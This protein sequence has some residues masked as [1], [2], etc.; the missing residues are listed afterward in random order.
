MWNVSVWLDD[1]E[2]TP[3]LRQSLLASATR[4]RTP[5]QSAQLSATSPTKRQRLADIDGNARQMTERTPSPVKERDTRRIADVGVFDEDDGRTPRQTR[6][7]SQK[8]AEYLTNKNPAS[9]VL[10]ARFKHFL[11]PDRAD[12]SSFPTRSS[13]SQASGSTSRSKSPVKDAVDLQVADIPIYQRTREE[14]GIP[15][16]AETLCKK[17][18]DIADGDG[19]VPK[20][21]AERMKQHGDTKLRPRHLAASELPFSE[22]DLDDFKQ[23]VEI[24]ED[25]R[26]LEK[27]NVHEAAWNSEVHSSVFRLALRPHKK[28]IWY[29]NIT[30]ARPVPAF[31]PTQASR[32]SE[33]RLVDYSVNIMPTLNEQRAIER[34]ISK[35]DEKQSTITQTRTTAVRTRPCVISIETKTDSGH[36]KAKNQLAVWGAAHFARMSSLFGPSREEEGANLSI[37]QVIHVQLHDWK[38]YLMV[39]RQA[40]MFIDE[41]DL[42][43]CI[44][45]TKSLLELWKLRASVRCLAQWAEE[46]YW[47]VLWRKLK[48]LEEN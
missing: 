20:L 42:D 45:G 14:V 27:D 23:L 32:I 10:D 26:Q 3:P 28:R 2:N 18:E 8:A 13:P 11:P 44:G 6:T 5:D 12:S 21:I 15:K 24:W 43:L 40:G 35:E 33:S 17:L 9:V 46:E 31:L 16:L 29:F 25:A 36:V 39:E 1:I 4:K 38:L 47:P 34:L 41:I 7:R 19:L 22:Y 30:Q 48:A 37:H